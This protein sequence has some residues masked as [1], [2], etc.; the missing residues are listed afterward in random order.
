M[1]WKRSSLVAGAA[2]SILADVAWAQDASAVVEEVIVTAQRRA[3]TLQDVPLAVSAVSGSDLQRRGLV[4]MRD[5]LAL[6]P[7]ATF[8]FINAA[9]PV[10]SVR[11]ISSGGEGAASDSGVLMMV[12]GEVISRDFL[13]GAPMFDVERVEVLRGPQGTTY[14]RNAT[15]GVLHVINRR[16]AA[17]PSG[18]A[19]LEIGDFGAFTLNAGGDLV[20]DDQTSA[21]LA[22]HYNSRDGYSTDVATGRD[23]D[24]RQALAGRLTFERRFGDDASTT[25]RLHASRERHG[26]TGPWK[27]YDPTLPL[28]GPPFRPDYVEPST[29]PYRIVTTPGGSFFDRDV[30]GLS[31]EL[32]LPFGW[33][34]L[35]SLTAF[36]RGDNHFF[37]GSPIGFN[38]V[39][40]RNAADV[41]SQE[42]RLDGELLGDRLYWVAG[43][44][45]L[46]EDVAFGYD[47]VGSAST[48][49]GPTT[50]SLRQTS[51]ARGYGLFGEAVWRMTPA[52]KLTLGGRFS[53]DEKDFWVDN[54]AN[55]PFAPFFVEDPSQPLTASVSDS[56]EQPTGRLSLEYRFNE[57]VMAYGTVS[58]GY[59][60]G[61]FNPEPS[62]LIAATTSFDEEK[63]TNF[64]AGVRTQLL[65]DRLRL[66]VT[67]FDMRY[68]DIQTGSFTAGGVEVIA[69]MGK[70]TIRG[71]E[72]EAVARPNRYVN[73]S[74]AYSAYDGT[75]DEF[76]DE[77]GNDL[78]GASLAKMPDWTFSASAVLTSPTIADA[79]AAQLRIDYVTRSD[80]A[81]DAP[82]DE[83]FGIR[84][85][86]DLID[87][88]LGWIPDQGD[89]EAAIFV[90]NVLDEAEIQYV[91]P[92]VILS[93][94]PVIY[95]PPRTWGVSLSY[96]FE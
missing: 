83:R 12:D 9:E 3:E 90:R 46:E 45:Y 59:K 63:V 2:M 52:L 69:N 60:S 58:Q 54:R 82:A 72:I 26:D 24:H 74:A 38:I 88:R 67:A 81:H 1:N 30:W 93:Q 91:G 48:T 37:Q 31:N 61:G 4:D 84:P 62:N 41:F 92:Q 78:S 10:L 29:D 17:S 73:L 34:K 27:S 32:I 16:P 39:D 42:L 80:V 66:N 50:Q 23:V 19:A 13:R 6:T 47:R 11:G 77:D 64:E 87:L 21:R 51:S 22:I 94:R 18:D 70:A 96:R 71:V 25:L 53:R 44:F 55:G 36:R 5:V 95:G 14:G 86:K 35:T 89:W 28:L 43:A 79:G 57:D 7:G 8:T 20:L 85:G 68:T 75:Y 15:G 40:V 76:V 49:F 65:D 56:W 33:A